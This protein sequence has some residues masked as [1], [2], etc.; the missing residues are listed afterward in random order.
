[1]KASGKNWATIAQLS[2]RYFLPFRLEHLSFRD[3]EQ[4]GFAVFGGGEKFDDFHFALLP[5]N[6]V[7]QVS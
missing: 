7:T 2:L 6:H 1:M 5:A 3:P 4:K